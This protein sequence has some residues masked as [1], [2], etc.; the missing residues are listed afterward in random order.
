MREKEGRRRSTRKG[1]KKEGTG[2]VLAVDG[3][4]RGEAIDS[5]RIQQDIDKNEG[6]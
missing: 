5:G 1:R 6:Q 2:S 3:R 4:R